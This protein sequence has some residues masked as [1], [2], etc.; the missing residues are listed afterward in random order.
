M[1]W[2]A[3]LSEADGDEP[4]TQLGGLGHA[5]R[6]A[7]PVKYQSARDY[8]IARDWVLARFG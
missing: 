5:N 8:E 2:V 3:A 4:M 1:R 7:R 6:R